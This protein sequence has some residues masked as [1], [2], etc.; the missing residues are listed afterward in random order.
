MKADSEFL[1]WVPVVS[2][3]VGGVMAIAGGVVTQVLIACKEKRHRQK[4]WRQKGRLSVPGSF[5]I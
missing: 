2:S 1:V 4:C 3:A 5:C